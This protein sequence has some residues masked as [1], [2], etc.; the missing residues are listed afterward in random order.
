METQVTKHGGHQAFRSKVLY[1]TSRSTKLCGLSRTSPACQEPLQSCAQACAHLEQRVKGPSG[2][3]C[4][5]LR[6]PTRVAAWAVC[7]S[8]LGTTQKKCQHVAIAS[9]TWS[10]HHGCQL[11]GNA[12]QPSILR[13]MPRAKARVIPREG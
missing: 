12:S 2:Y 4:G 1:C 10:W 7:R 8:F 3:V 9:Q 13:A 11:S 5:W 6:A